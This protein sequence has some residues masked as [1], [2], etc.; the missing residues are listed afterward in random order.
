MQ[1][2]A[3]IS[4]ASDFFAL[5]NVI[6]YLGIYIP[7]CVGRRAKESGSHT[8]LGAAVVMPFG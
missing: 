7:N 4:K 2:H 1:P 5:S 8:G 3:N 6:S